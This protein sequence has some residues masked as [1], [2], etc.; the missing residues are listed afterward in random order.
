MTI[1][2]RSQNRMHRIQLQICSFHS[3]TPL[4]D[5]MIRARLQN[6]NPYYF[7]IHY[8]LREMNQS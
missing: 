3:W 4:K 6:W 5:K 2:Q 8:A 7:P 1:W